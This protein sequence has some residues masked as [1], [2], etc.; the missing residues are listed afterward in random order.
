MMCRKSFFGRQSTAVTA[1]YTGSSIDEL[2]HKGRMALFS[3][4]DA[5]AVELNKLPLEQRTAQEFRRLMKEVPLP[6]MFV[7]YRNDEFCGGDDE[8]RQ[9]YLL[10][11]VDAGAEVV[12]V[13]GDLYDPSEYELTRDPKA[14]DRQM[15]LIDEIHRRGGKVVMSSHMQVPRTAEEV[16]EHLQE[17][18]RRGADIVKI[19]VGGNT[20]EDLQES[21]RTMI[22]LREKMDRPYIYL[23]G[24]AC[25]T[26]IRN[27][28]M[29]FGV[30]VEFANLDNMQENR[31]Q[32]P[33][34]TFK[35]VQQ[36]LHWNIDQ[37]GI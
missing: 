36:N 31:V 2:I 28:G 7:L 5:I 4:A 23:V 1:I 12:D 8:A 16:L 37:L 22:L 30:A 15:Q 17:Q 13:M 27:L 21:I 18:A 19:V 35:A 10:E 29:C 3:D 32:A 26:I 20:K 33:I 11:A 34:A 14:I 25:A 6:F 9:K 24:G